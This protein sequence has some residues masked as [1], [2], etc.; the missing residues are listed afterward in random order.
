MPLTELVLDM[1]PPE[2]VAAAARGLSYRDFLTVALVGPDDDAFPDN[3]IYVHTPGV[4]VGRV[5][6]FGS[7][8]PYLVKDGHTCLGLEHFVNEGDELWRL[9]DEELVQLA[10]DELSQLGLARADHVEAGYVVRVPKAYPVYDEG[11]AD[12]VSVMRQWLATNAANVQPVGRNGMHK[13]N[14]Q[15]HSMLTA[16][17]AVEN[18]DGAHHDLWSVNV[19]R[20]TTRSA[21]TPAAVATRRPFHRSTRVNRRRLATSSRLAWWTPA[22]VEVE[23]SPCSRSSSAVRSRSGSCSAPA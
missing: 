2:A 5:Q 18:L 11:Y 15:D 7:W 8:S 19:E 10:K 22:V 6:N 20:S 12:R 21:A 13:Y 17:L 16:M 9:P 4:R 3:W 14:T 23:E 1:A